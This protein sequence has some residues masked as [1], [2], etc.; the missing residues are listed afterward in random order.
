M[1]SGFTQTDLTDEEIRK[2]ISRL[3]FEIKEYP[4][5][6]L[7]GSRELELKMLEEE[8]RLRTD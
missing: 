8:I 2:E 5:S 4:K 3:K 1:S 6:Y 7:R